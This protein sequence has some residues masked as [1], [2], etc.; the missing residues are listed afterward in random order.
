MLLYFV[1]TGP[2]HFKSTSYTVK[3][4]SRSLNIRSRAKIKQAQSQSQFPFTYGVWKGKGKGLKNN[5]VA[6]WI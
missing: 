5:T 6:P 2:N 4:Y 1:P 3:K